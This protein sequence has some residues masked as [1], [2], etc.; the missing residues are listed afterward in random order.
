MLLEDKTDYLRTALNREVVITKE[1]D[2]VDTVV[3]PLTL[4]ERYI[5]RDAINSRS[6]TAAL[7]FRLKDV[8]AYGESS[9]IYM[10]DLSPYVDKVKDDRYKCYIASSNT[11]RKLMHAVVQHDTPLGSMRCIIEQ[12]GSPNYIAILCIRKEEKTGIYYD[13]YNDPKVHKRDNTVKETN[14]S[15]L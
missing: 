9:D 4:T 5:V 2:T 8:V 1:E 12:L 14:S 15:V 3:I 7:Q 10:A 11:H 6:E 13:Y